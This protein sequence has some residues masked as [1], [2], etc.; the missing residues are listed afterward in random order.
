MCRKKGGHFYVVFCWGGKMSVA[1]RGKRG[2]EI[3]ASKKTPPL[4]RPGGKVAG[5]KKKESAVGGV[6]ELISDF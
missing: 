5:D 1:R 3:E 2:R 6:E 4:T